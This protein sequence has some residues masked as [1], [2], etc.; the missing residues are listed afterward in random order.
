MV[1]VGILPRVRKKLQD[2]ATI[3][4]GYTSGLILVGILPRV[5][6]KL[7]DFTT[8]TDRYI[9]EMVPISILPRVGK[10]LQDFATITDRHIDDKRISQSARLSEAW[11]VSTVTDGCA[12]D[13]FTNRLTDDSKSQAGFLKFLVRFS[14]NYRWN[15]MPLTTINV[16]LV[17]LLEILQYKNPPPPIWF[18]SLSALICIS[19]LLSVSIKFLQKVL[20]FW[21]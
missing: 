14:I 19:P 10:T 8:I 18:I 16:S 11:S 20:L 13:T 21:W 17:I 3:T 15:L 7:R 4:D 9:D 12:D 2:F 1:P 5:E 6:K